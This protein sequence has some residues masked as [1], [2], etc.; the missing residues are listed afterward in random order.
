M[1]NGAVTTH[2][3]LLVQVFPFTDGRAFQRGLYLL[4]T[5]YA[6]IWQLYGP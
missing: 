1:R 2:V 4:R 6:R 3:G 5:G